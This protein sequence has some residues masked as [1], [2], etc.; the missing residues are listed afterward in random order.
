MILKNTVSRKISRLSVQSGQSGNLR[1]SGQ[2]GQS[3]QSRQQDPFLWY[4]SG[5]LKF[6]KVGTN[7]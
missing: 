7:I 2:S 6:I 1:L 5:E 3:A 4:K